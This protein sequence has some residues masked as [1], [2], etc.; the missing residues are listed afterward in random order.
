MSHS[1]INESD[2]HLL[3]FTAALKESPIK[4]KPF[5]PKNQTVAATLPQRD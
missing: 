2:E 3:E 5:L 4:V 1:S